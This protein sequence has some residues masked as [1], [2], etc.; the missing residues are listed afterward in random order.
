MNSNGP[1]YI[2]GAG[3]AGLYCASLLSKQKIHCVVLEKNNKPG[4]KIIISGGGRCN[5]TNTTIARD[6]FRGQSKNFHWKIIL[7]H[8]N[9][10]F[11]DLV[12]EYNIEF[13]EKKLGQLFCKNSS[14]E[15]L[16]L[17]LSQIDMNYCKISFNEEVKFI[18]RFNENFSIKTHK[19]LHQTKYCVISSGGLPM[20]II[21][22]TD[23]GIKTAKKFNIEVSNTEEA[24]V[25]IKISGYTTLSGISIKASIQLSKNKKI[26]DDLLFTHNGLSGPLILKATLY[27]DVGENLTFDLLPDIELDEVLK[28]DIRVCIT[29]TLNKYFP[30]R[31]VDFIMEKTNVRHLPPLELSNKEIKRCIDYIKYH[32]I[33]YKRNEGYRKAEVMKGGVLTKE[34]SKRL[35]SRKVPNLY[36]IGETVDVTGLLGG[37]NFQWAWSSAFSCADHIIEKIRLDKCSSISPK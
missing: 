21:G 37:Y 3:A 30:K 31:L 7:N 35:E 34:L 33:L 20:P 4:K 1:V 11:I 6:D 13:Y 5:F 22:G 17:L 24:L 36:F 10:K 9:T 18:D 27:F 26:V 14:K 28:R 32:K 16:Q 29:K 25:P 8:P 19:K 23:F 15:I 12:K 2:I